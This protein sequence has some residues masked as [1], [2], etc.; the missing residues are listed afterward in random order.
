MTVGEIAALA[1]RHWVVVAV[2]LILAGAALHSIKN[3]PPGYQ[4]SST[5]IFVAPKSNNFPNPYDSDSDAPLITTGEITVRAMMSPQSHQL[6]QAAGGSADFSVE[7]VNLYNQEYPDYGVPDAT[8]TTT[9]TSWE[10]THITYEIV[11]RQLASRLAAMQ[12]GVKA[13]NRI[14]A[15][16]VG[17]SGPIIQTGSPKRVYAGLILLTLIAFFMLAI[18]LDRH[19]RLARRPAR[20]RRAMTLARRP[21]ASEPS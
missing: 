1:R 12:A 13:H 16:T 9:G 2:V 17:D 7:L 18:F 15:N 6:V 19:P 14:T 10:A 11:T 8:I 20:A 5:L 4:E 21:Q 3:S